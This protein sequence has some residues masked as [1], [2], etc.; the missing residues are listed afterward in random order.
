MRPMERRARKRQAHDMEVHSR[1]TILLRR[2]S[3]RG[4]LPVYLRGHE[5]Y[6]RQFVP[7][8]KSLSRLARSLE[9][10]E[11]AAAAN[12][13][14]GDIG[15]VVLRAPLAAL[16]AYRKSAR[17]RPECAASWREMG[18]ML[19]M[20]GRY[21]AAKRA[22]LR[23]SRLD[24]HDPLVRADLDFAD[25][26]IAAVPPPLFRRG[27]IEW[28]CNEL[29]AQERPTSVLRLLGRRRSIS[30]MKM[31]ARA[32]AAMSNAAQALE[33]WRSIQHRPGKVALQYC[34]WFYLRGVLGDNRE[35][36]TILRSLSARLTDGI[37]PIHASLHAVVSDRL[38]AAPYS[39]GALAGLHRRWRLMCDY[40]IACI[41]RDALHM[42]ALADKYPGWVEAR[43]AAEK[44]RGEKVS[45]GKGGKVK[46]GR[47]SKGEKVSKGGKGVRS[48]R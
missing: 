15:D 1:A 14:I 11:L 42:K 23:A 40:H 2:Y 36:W 37:Y 39:R 21:R 31:R 28:R 8:A 20:V 46:G 7:A 27:S 22:W 5:W 9:E 45:E 6:K 34:D 41:G 35:W 26:D 17:L 30:D 29:M 47:V 33:E 16:R 25:G 43:T 18:S 10:K 4:F 32:Y 24:P 13:V 12:Y 38:H 19:H 3:D 48:A 44:L